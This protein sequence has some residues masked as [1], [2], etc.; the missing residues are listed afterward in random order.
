MLF[1]RPKPVPDEMPNAKIWLSFHDCHD[2]HHGTDGRR[3]DTV[4]G[5]IRLIDG[6]RLFY[7]D[8][9]AERAIAAIEG[10][11]DLVRVLTGLRKTEEVEA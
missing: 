8:E 11:T 5:L 7:G 2:C 9:A 6:L 4:V 10:E 1:P 3:Y